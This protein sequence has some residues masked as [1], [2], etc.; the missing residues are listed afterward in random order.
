MARISDTNAMIGGMNPA[1]QS[2]VWHFCTCPP[3]QA[4]AMLAHALASMQEAEGLSLILPEAQAAA[5]GLMSENPM[6]MI[7]LQVNS[8]LDGVGLTAAV[9]TALTQASIPCNVVAANHHDHIFVPVDKA[10][11]AVQTLLGLA[12]QARH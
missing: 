3:E 7:T 10:D 2:G 8:A 6:V 1:L 11:S 4:A 9:A 5:A 12:A